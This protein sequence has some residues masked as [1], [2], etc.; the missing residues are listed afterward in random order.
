MCQALGLLF[1]I[2]TY[3]CYKSE[4]LGIATPTFQEKKITIT[5]IVNVYIM[6]AV[7]QAVE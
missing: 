1:M 3:F 2:S 4:R 5:N 6:L 7:Y